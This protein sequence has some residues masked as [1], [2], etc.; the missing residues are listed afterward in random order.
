M[1]DSKRVNPIILA[2][3]D[4]GEEYTLEFSRATVQAAEQR[5]FNLSELLDFPATNIPALFFYA[6]RMHHPN[7]G[8]GKTDKLLKEL[9]GLT[10]DE[11]GR[12][13]DLYNA[14]TET[15]IVKDPETE[16]KNC[17]LTLTM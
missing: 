15:L 3:P 7:V 16:R 1:A 14:A 9:G 10:S 6:F 11:A 13:V 12:L 4:S 5:G 2:D 17:R 8:R